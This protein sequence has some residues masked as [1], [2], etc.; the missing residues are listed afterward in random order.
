MPPAQCVGGVGGAPSPN[1]DRLTSCGD[2]TFELDDITYSED[3]TET[4]TG[5][6]DFEDVQWI[7]FTGTGSTWTHGMI[8]Y[9]YTGTGDL[10]DGFDAT[11]NSECY[12]AEGVWSADS[13]T[14]PDPRTV[15]ITDNGTYDFEWLEID[16]GPAS[17]HGRPGGLPG[18]LPGSGLGG[19]S[20]GWR[21]C[22][23]DRRR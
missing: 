2:T 22:V 5:T 15:A 1:P 16:E 9:S 17:H 10:S 21:L 8:T 23:G 18:G 6:F 12:L 13:E 14:N 19:I 20:A 3:G 11:I 4:V 7:S